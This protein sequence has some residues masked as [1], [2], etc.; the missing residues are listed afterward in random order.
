FQPA[1]YTPFAQRDA[2]SRVYLLRTTGDPTAMASAVRRAFTDVDPR[3]SV[4]RAESMDALVRRSFAEERYRTALVSLFGVL[5]A[6]L[7]AVGM[8]GV[9]ARAVAGRTREVGIRLALGAPVWSVVRQ[10]VGFTLTGVGLG[11]A[12]GLVGAAA[13]GRALAPF[14]FGV[15][16]TDPTTFLGVVALL[17]VVSVTASLVPARRAGRIEIVRVLRGD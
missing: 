8:Y 15:N 12:L 4:T 11:V 13:A 2:W 9:T 16:P 14:L 1:I 5:S 17:G 7:A 6:V 10:L 3:L